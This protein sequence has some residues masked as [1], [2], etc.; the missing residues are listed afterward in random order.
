MKIFDFLKKKSVNDATVVRK[1]CEIVRPEIGSPYSDSTSTQKYR[2]WIYTCSNYNAQ[3]VADANFRLFTTKQ[4]PQTRVRKVNQKELKSMNIETNA[5]EVMSHPILDLLA[6]PNE[7]D[8]FYSFLYKIQTYLELTGDSYVYISRAPNGI[9]IELTVLYSQAVTIVQDGYGEIDYYGYGKYLNGKYQHQLNKQDV[10]H[11]K[12]FDPDNTQ[13]YGISP[14]QACATANGLIES[15]DIYEQAIN[16]NMGVP[17]GVLKMQES[18]IR[19]KDR[20]AVEGYWNRKFSS[21]GRSG[22]TLVL[23]KDME[24]DILGISPKE[25]Q[26]LEGRKYSQNQIF[27]CFGINPAL[28]LTENVN[29][30]NMVAAQVN[31]HQNTLKPR[32]KLIAQ[33]LT[34]Q[35]IKPNSIDGKEVFVILHKDAPVD[36]DQKQ[37]E[38]E[39]LANSGALSLNE[40]R[41]AY[42]YSRIESPEADELMK[43]KQSEPKEVSNE[44]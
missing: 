26:W 35:L 25:M 19:E 9:P 36:I 32:L 24:Y 28:I 12:F 10:I 30:S 21:V 3:N 22:K 40:L 13:H 23:G 42:G 17:T 33:T 15:A 43:P 44:E 20:E 18:Q 38:T 31:Y 34:N 14:L 6:K 7:D 4:N 2:G 8:S 1:L 27:S 16:R 39:F 37:K 41:T 29:R 11:F 5:S